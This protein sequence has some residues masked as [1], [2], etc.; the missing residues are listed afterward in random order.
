MNIHTFIIPSLVTRGEK[1]V[2]AREQYVTIVKAAELLQV[3][4]ST[5]WRWINKGELP[6]YRFGYRRVLIKQK[7]LDK[8]ITPARREKGEAMAQAEQGKTKPMTAREQE[9][10]LEAIDKVRHLQQEML[11]K[12]GG[13]LFAPSHAILDELRDQRTSNV[14]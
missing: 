13:K 10:A 7:D 8:L 4:K 1:L 2:E 11:A 5:L 3:S 6:A 14:R 12:R 9:L